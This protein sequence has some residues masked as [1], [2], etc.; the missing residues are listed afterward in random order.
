MP[1][2]PILEVEIF[3]LWGIDFMGPFLVSF[4]NQFNL[5][6]VDYLSKLYQLGQM[7]I[8]LSSSF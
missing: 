8:E 4:G 1:L 7:T 3:D 6:A 2:I 5:V